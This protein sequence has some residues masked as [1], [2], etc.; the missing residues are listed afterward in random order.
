MNWRLELTYGRGK[1]EF[2]VAFLIKI[3]GEKH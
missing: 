3:K 1:M 2:E